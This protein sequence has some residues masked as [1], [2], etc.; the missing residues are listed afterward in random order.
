MNATV[1]ESRAT[2]RKGTLSEIF[3]EAC[4]EKAVHKVQ[5]KNLNVQV[6]KF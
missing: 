5:F 2:Q 3:K 4:I 1:F 6:R